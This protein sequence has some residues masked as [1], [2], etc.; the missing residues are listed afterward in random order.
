LLG[1][2]IGLSLGA[3]FL[4]ARPADDAAAARFHAVDVAQAMARRQVNA[5]YAMNVRTDA[6]AAARRRSDLECLTDV[7]YYEAR[8]ESPRGQAA[9]AQVV[10][11][12]VKH[13]AF[14]KSVCGVVFQ[15]ASHPGCQFS[16]ACD[17]SMRRGRE[18]LAWDRARSIATRVLAGALTANVGSATHFHTTSVSPFWAPSMLRV[19]T[20]GTHVFY[21]FSPYRLRAVT[22]DAP[23][24]DQ[25]VLTAGAADQVPTLRLTPASVA[26][27]VE[28]SLQPAT[29]GQASPA[30]AKVPVSAPTPSPKPA[31]SALLTGPQPASAAAS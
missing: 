16:F 7:V 15:G 14:P 2:A 26:D 21:R 5:T 22:P 31:E 29:T 20:V 8:G 9:V 6:A 23:E 13:P 3:S 12:R 19:T 30:A 11:N 1:S 27:A 25:A 17:G 4:A 28:A 18:A 24:L 10:L